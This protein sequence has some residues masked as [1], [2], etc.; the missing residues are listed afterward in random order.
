MT[1]EDAER[2]LKSRPYFASQMV[3]SGDADG[4]VGELV[5]IM[6]MYYGRQ[7]K[8][9]VQIPQ[10]IVLLAATWLM[11]RVGQFSLLMRQ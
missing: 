11:S 2:L 7:S 6:Q 1:L 10:H 8:S 3:A 4:F 9:S 5:G